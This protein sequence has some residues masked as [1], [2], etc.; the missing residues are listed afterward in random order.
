MVSVWAQQVGN[1]YPNSNV[2]PDGLG[3]IGEAL[4]KADLGFL[5]WVEPERAF[6]GTQMT[7]EHPEWMLGPA[8]CEPFGG[9]VYMYNLGTP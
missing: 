2:Y 8:W 6:E 4:Q 5:L 1:L 9:N 7:Q 3:P